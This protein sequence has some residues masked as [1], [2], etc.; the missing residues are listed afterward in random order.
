MYKLFR[1]GRI[2]CRVR[3]LVLPQVRGM[4]LVNNTTLVQH[5]IEFNFADLLNPLDVNDRDCS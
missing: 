1:N 3:K 2:I 4:V 5:S